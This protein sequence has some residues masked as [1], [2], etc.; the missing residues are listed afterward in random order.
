MNINPG[1]MLRLITF[2]KT[3]QKTYLYS[4]W[5]HLPITL[6]ENFL[7]QAVNSAKN[8]EQVQKMKEA[9]RLAACERSWE[10]VFEAV[11]RI[12]PR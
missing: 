7:N 5:R 2:C 4:N 10:R 3:W 8:P 11:Y 1:S 6:S 9:A 12:Q